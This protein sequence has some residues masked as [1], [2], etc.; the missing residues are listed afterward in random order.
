MTLLIAVM[1]AR[2]HADLHV[3]YMLYQS[4]CVSSR[5]TSA[6]A[7]VTASSILTTTSSKHKEQAVNSWNGITTKV[8]EQKR[9]I[10]MGRA[11]TRANTNWTLKTR[12]RK[13]K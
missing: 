12:K 11:K 5:R 1:E 9:E 4:V 13:E 3:F 10:H 6:I 8:K 7:S 2:T